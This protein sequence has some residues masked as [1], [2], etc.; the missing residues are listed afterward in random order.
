MID[1]ANDQ[2]DPHIDVLLKLQVITKTVGLQFDLAATHIKA[3]I[4]VSI[5]FYIIHS[6]YKLIKLVNGH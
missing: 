3:V 1:V 2:E 6:Y 5:L 4:V